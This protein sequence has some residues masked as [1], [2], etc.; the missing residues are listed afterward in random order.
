MTMARA[1]SVEKQRYWRA[2]VRRQKGSGLSV[3]AF[4]RLEGVSEAS[5]YAWKRRLRRDTGQVSGT[6]GSA[7]PKAAARAT[8]K[9][10]SKMAREPAPMAA[11][12]VPVRISGKPRRPMFQVRWPGG[13]SVR[14]P[15][16]CDRADVEVVLRAVDRLARQGREG[17]AC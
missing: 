6:R 5:F 1:K 3:A 13:F 17:E 7:T 9:S 10:R 11:G 15:T 2:V 8:G 4:C 12:F 16:A 14:I